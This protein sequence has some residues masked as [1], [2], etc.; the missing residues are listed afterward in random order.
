MEDK[1]GRASTARSGCERER[2]R[3]IIIPKLR[4]AFVFIWHDCLHVLLLAAVGERER[5]RGEGGRTRG[6]R[7]GEE[8]REGNE[9]VGKETNNNG[10]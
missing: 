9:V 10:E 6:E 7:D 3:E 2:E 8:R 1:S 4:T 5:E